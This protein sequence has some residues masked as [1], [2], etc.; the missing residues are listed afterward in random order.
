MSEPPEPAPERWPD[1]RAR[2]SSGFGPAEPGSWPAG[3][4]FAWHRARSGRG[5]GAMPRPVRPAGEAPAL[6]TMFHVEH[7][8]A[9]GIRT[10]PGEPL[11]V[12]FRPADAASGRTGIARLTRLLRGRSRL[13]DP[14]SRACRRLAGMAT[15]EPD[16]GSRR[17]W[18]RL[19]MPPVARSA[20]CGFRRREAERIG[21]AGVE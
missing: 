12:R 11:V 8:V 16:R 15:Q 5:P 2:R 1:G 21:G 20:R 3:A 9:L 7:R 13:D 18:F 19:P 6:V 14:V 10:T 4:H 17:R